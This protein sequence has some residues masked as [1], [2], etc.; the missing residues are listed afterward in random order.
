MYLKCKY[1]NDYVFPQSYEEITAYNVTKPAV[2]TRISKTLNSMCLCY[3]NIGVDSRDIKPSATKTGPRIPVKPQV[4][5]NLKT[6][7][8]ILCKSSFIIFT[9]NNP[10]VSEIPALF[11][12]M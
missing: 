4:R 12:H 2:T 7:T 1:S 6:L 11:A 10:N 8:V 3:I 9:N 5:L